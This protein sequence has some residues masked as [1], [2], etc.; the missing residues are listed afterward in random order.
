VPRQD[1]DAVAAGRRISISPVSYNQ[2]DGFPSLEVSGKFSQPAMIRTRAGQLVFGT[3]RGA[4]MLDPL[5]LPV[6]THPPPVVIERVVANGRTAFD[7]GPAGANLAL[8]KDGTRE[9]KEPD[10]RNAGLELPPGSGRTFEIQY[11]ANSFIAPEETRFKYRLEG[12]DKNWID[13]G[14]SRKAYYA[15]LSPGSYTFHVIAVNKYGIWNAAGAQLSMRL[16]PLFYETWTFYVACGVVLCLAMY[17]GIQ[18]RIKELRKIDQ[19]RHQLALEEQRKRI[20]RDIHDELGAS[21]T[22]IA[23]LSEETDALLRQSGQ[24]GVQ[25]GHITTLAEE[26][27]GNIGEIVWANNPRYDTLDDAVAFLREYAAKFLGA[28]PLESRLAFPERIPTRA[29]SGPFRR[30]LLAILKESLQNI[31][32]HAAAT[33]VEVVLRLGTGE[34]ELTVRDN[35]R[36]MNAGPEPT[37][38]NGLANMRERATELQGSIELKSQAG[39]GTTVHVRVPLPPI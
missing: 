23:Y 26:A 30:H 24:A 39:K 8:Q 6:G 1:L 28:T 9:K 31:L 18:W 22:Q 17:S 14:T 5:R 19:L 3:S 29:V 34:L 7:N 16:A 25:P 15:N 11:T 4:V 27:V 38:G 32:K 21:L 2:A 20:A 10:V 33:R 35:G 36:G 12:W 37:F 13:G